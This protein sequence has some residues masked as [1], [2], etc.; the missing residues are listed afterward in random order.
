MLS[1]PN[2]L[3]LLPRQP[4]ADHADASDDLPL[5]AGAVEVDGSQLE[6]GG[7]ILRNSTAL[8][9]ITGQPIRISKIRAGGSASSGHVA[10]DHICVCCG[11]CAA[12]NTKR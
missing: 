6:G 4:P 9:A 10:T 1:P 5:P 3:P 7:Q 8:A 12:A 2:S 11:T